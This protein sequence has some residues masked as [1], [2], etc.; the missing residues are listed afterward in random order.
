[1]AVD[2]NEAFGG[3]RAFSHR[4]TPPLAGPYLTVRWRHNDRVSGEVWASALSTDVA[5]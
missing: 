5:P 2:R 1:M 4:R 3:R